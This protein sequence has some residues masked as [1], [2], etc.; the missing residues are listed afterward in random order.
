MFMFKDKKKCF[1]KKKVAS[2]NE[3]LEQKPGVM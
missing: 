2:A 3:L 1:K